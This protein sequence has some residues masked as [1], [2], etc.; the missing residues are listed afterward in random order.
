MAFLPAKAFH[1]GDGH[2]LYPHLCESFFHL[3]K[4]EGFNDGFDL[5]HKI[6]SQ[7]VEGLWVYGLLGHTQSACRG[8]PLAAI[9]ISLFV[10]KA[11]FLLRFSETI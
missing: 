3:I 6:T 4:L 7:M 1:F 11:R 10:G 5:L 8:S 2:S 9:C